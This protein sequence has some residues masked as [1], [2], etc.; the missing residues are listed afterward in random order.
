MVVSLLL[1]LLLLAVLLLTT[2]FLVR[3]SVATAAG[4]GVR[5]HE[6]RQLPFFAAVAVEASVVRGNTAHAQQVKH[7]HARLALQ[8]LGDLAHRQRLHVEVAHGEEQITGKDARRLGSPAAHHLLDANAPV[9]LLGRCRS[10]A[11]ARRPPLVQA[12]AHGQR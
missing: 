11:R 7:H 10:G 9:V 12:R 4:E 8:E 1:L 5:G 2:T 6:A 3:R